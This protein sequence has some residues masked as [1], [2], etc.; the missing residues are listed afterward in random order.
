M[1]ALLSQLR[2]STSSAN[3]S[4]GVELARR[5]Q[6]FL[7]KSQQDEIK[8]RLRDPKKLVSH[9]VSLWP[10]EEDWHCD[11]KGEDPCEHTLA[12]A[13]YY[14]KNPKGS[15]PQENK[16]IPWKIVYYFYNKSER[17]FLKRALRKEEEEKPL[18]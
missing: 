3:W 15:S 5:C 8:L 11:C 16:R 2:E 9:L 12:A 7:E 1:Q 14:Q 13:I 4:K 17:L 18:S 6:V 10:Q